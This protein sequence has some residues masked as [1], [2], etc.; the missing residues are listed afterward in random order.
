MIGGLPFEVTTLRC[1]VETDGRR[2]VVAFGR[3]FREDALRRDFTIN[4]LALD[5]AGV[6]HDYA[7]GLADLEARRVRFIGAAEERIAEDYLR[8]LRFFRFHARYGAGER[9]G[10]RC[11]PA[12]PAAPA[13]TDCRGNGSAPNSSSCSWRRARRRRCGPWPGPGC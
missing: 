4:A 13:W 9:T 3:D 12:S 7:G 5:G 2:A 11:M 10:R 6:L 8:I 1:D